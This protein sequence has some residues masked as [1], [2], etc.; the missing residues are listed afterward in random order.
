MAKKSSKFNGFSSNVLDI[1][2][3]GAFHR[4][5]KAGPKFPK[6]VVR[7]GN[8]VQVGGRKGGVKK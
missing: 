5:R 7:D 3:I 1:K 6:F 4:P 2:Q 8:I